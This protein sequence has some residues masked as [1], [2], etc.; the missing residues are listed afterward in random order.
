M[1]SCLCVDFH[2][3]IS[4]FDKD[5]HH[6]RWRAQLNWPHLDELYLQQ[7]YFQIRSH[8]EVLGVR[9][10]A[11]EVF[12]QGGYNS[13]HNISLGALFHL[14]W[15]CIILW[16]K[17]CLYSKVSNSRSSLTYPRTVDE[18]S[19]CI[20]QTEPPRW[21]GKLFKNADFQVSPQT[22]WI[23]KSGSRALQSVLTNTPGKSDTGWF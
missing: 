2:V 23:R 9:T 4:P 3:Q 20:P 21:P 8:S 18:F 5:I 13:I 12:L 17:C 11:C 6:I 14:R 16:L 1:A 15:S 19:K 10:S 7:S 22:Y